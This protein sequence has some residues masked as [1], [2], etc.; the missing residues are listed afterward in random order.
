[1]IAVQEALERAVC[2]HLKGDLQPAAEIYES[3]LEQE[4]ANADALHLKGVLAHQRGRFD[5][6]I[7]LLR[8]AVAIQPAEQYRR[9]LSAALRTVGRFDEALDVVLAAE[10]AVPR[11][12]NDGPAVRSLPVSDSAGIAAPGRDYNRLE[13]I[14][15]GE[16][17][18]FLVRE[19]GYSSYLEI[20]CDADQTFSLIQASHRVGVDPVS[21]GTL[22]MTSDEFFRVS[23]ETFELVFIDGA[24][25]HQQVLRDVEHAL[26]CLADGGAIVLHD[27][28]PTEEIQQIHPR[29]VSVWTGDVWRA[30]VDLRH[31]PDLDLA[32]L[33]S[34][35]GLGV[36][37]ARPAQ[38]FLSSQVPAGA[39]L[40]WTDYCC[41]R[42]QLLRVVDTAG[43]LRFIRDELTDGRADV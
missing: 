43:M 21:G 16:L 33:D 9:N 27:C 19:R 18:N 39:R 28:L 35:F 8:H 24:H 32:V 25:E 17:L 34:D 2:L 7:R 14:V 26:G 40:T 23:Q 12:Q 13:Q 10:S 5:D 20:G 29:Q 37:F 42:D 38:E 22:R 6:A 36:L 11:P 30:V 41:D 31:R 15:R 3:V 1:M 4:P